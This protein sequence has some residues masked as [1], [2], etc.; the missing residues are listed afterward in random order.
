MKAGEL[1]KILQDNFSTGTLNPDDDIMVLNE[2][3]D[4]FKI[5]TAEC[6]T[7]TSDFL[8]IIENY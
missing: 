6:D 8:I 4:T 7:Q 5:K 3:N 2:D 1:V